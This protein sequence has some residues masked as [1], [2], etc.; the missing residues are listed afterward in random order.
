MINRI[1]LVN[2]T[3][4]LE[5]RM[6]LGGVGGMEFYSDLSVHFEDIF[7]LREPKLDLIR[8]HAQQ[9]SRILDIGCST[10]ELVT[11]LAKDGY[12]C[13]GTDLNPE[14]I[15]RARLLADSEGVR[16]DF[17]VGDMRK[18]KKLYQE[19]FDVISCFGNTIVHLNAAE[20]I[21]DFFQQVYNLLKSGGSFIF[22]IINY[23][24]VLVNDIKELPT[25]RNEEQGLTFF[26]DYQYDPEAHLIHFKTRLVLDDNEEK[27]H[28]ITL[29]PL[30]SK[31]IEEMVYS[32]GF[33]EIEF[34]GSMRQEAFDPV[35]SM[36]L[37]AVVHKG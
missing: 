1:G 29:Y 32:V 11:T 7:P 13:Y 15:E 24:R 12:T 2:K 26:R 20:E 10:G 34:F 21:Q 27:G 36:P 3:K 4:L 17:Q 28:S 35:S 22:Q 37:V 14:M 19:P 33:S 25:I 18:L 30:R 23:D 6:E 9:D 16:V 8:K 31:E 5:D